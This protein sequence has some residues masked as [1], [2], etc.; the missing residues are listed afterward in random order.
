[1]VYTFIVDGKS[2]DLPKKTVSVMSKMD[3]VLKVD[4]MTGL[5]VRQKY[6]KLHNFMKDV[7][8]RENCK[9]MF[10]SEKLD[11]IDLSELTI[12]VRKVVSAYDKPVMDYDMELSM[13]RLEH[14]PLEQLTSVVNAAQTV[15]SMESLNKK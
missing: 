2:Y 3:D 8:G 12:A 1:M 11:E 9:E 6:E 14:L 15:A 13:N 10:G 5:T 4:S 7:A